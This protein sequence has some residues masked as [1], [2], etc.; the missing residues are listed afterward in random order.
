LDDIDIGED[1]APTPASPL[2][3]R[4]A[5][6]DSAHSAAL[7]ENKKVTH[8]RVLSPTRS[9]WQYESFGLGVL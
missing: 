6:A 3:E 7:R 5:A 1:S 2:Q 4:V 9:D 8:L